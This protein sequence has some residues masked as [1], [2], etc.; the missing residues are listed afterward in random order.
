MLNNHPTNSTML[1][2]LAF[3]CQKLLEVTL[4]AGWHLCDISYTALSWS[5]ETFLALLQEICRILYDILASEKTQELCNAALESL[6]GFL[7]GVLKLVFFLISKILGG[8]IIAVGSGIE[9]LTS[10]EAQ[11]LLVD[12]ANMI[13]FIVVSLFNT[14]TGKHM[15]FILGQLNSILWRLFELLG[16]LLVGILNGM[17]HLLG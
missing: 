3:I 7:E 8:C 5:I 6:F 10:N 16:K 1:S 12:I 13:V 4:I 14:L 17:G 11:Q 15:Q 9:L 2:S